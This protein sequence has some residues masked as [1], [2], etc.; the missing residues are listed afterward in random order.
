MTLY[1]SGEKDAYG[2]AARQ[3]ASSTIRTIETPGGAGGEVERVVTARGDERF[4]D[5]EVLVASDTIVPDM[6]GDW[7]PK[8]EAPDGRSFDVVGVN[9][10]AR[11]MG[12]LR[13]LCSRRRS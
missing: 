1:T 2:D 7:L 6:T 5:T 13:L 9:P 12:F 4:V 8:L 3:P 11:A 10:K